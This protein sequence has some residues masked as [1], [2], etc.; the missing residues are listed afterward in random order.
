[1]ITD[2]ERRTLSD[3]DSELEDIPALRN[4]AK[5][6]SPPEAGTQRQGMSHPP[7]IKTLEDSETDTWGIPSSQ[8]TKMSPPYQV[9]SAEQRLYHAEQNLGRTVNRQMELGRTAETLVNAL[10]SAV[11]QIEKCK[12]R[13]ITA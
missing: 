2:I 10:G 5:E 13:K 8:Q 1:M 12:L 4:S 11:S 7:R 6:D 9:T 3:P